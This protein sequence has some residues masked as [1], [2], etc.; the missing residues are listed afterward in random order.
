MTPTAH[1][2]LILAL[3][4]VL[5]GVA[6]TACNKPEPPAGEM[7]PPAS[8]TA[9]ADTAAPP[10]AEATPPPSDSRMAAWPDS[11]PLW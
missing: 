10:P 3:S 6:L 7:P 1:R 2:K 11:S 5:S 8:E 9:P 4:A